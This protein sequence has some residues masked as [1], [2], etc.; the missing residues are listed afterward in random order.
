MN[1]DPSYVKTVVCRRYKP[2]RVV[3]LN[4]SCVLINRN[5]PPPLNQ[6]FLLFRW[7]LIFTSIVDDFWGGT[8]DFFFICYS[9]AKNSRKICELYGGG[10]G[11]MANSEKIRFCAHS[12]GFQWITSE[13]NT[14]KY[15][16]FQRTNIGKLNSPNQ[17][18]YPPTTSFSLN[19]RNLSSCSS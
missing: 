16:K 2:K 15:L 6:K 8:L 14:S 11:L 12:L 13:L 3:I 18:P 1:R 5:S 7:G 4:N 9:D 19:N 17:Q 10:L